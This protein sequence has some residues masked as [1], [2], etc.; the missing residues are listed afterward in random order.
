ME[1]ISI[2]INAQ[3]ILLINNFLKSRHGQGKFFFDTLLDCS[4]MN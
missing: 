1:L 2:E 3:I 4:L